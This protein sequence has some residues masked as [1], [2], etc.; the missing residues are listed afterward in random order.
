MN[1]RVRVLTLSYHYAL[2]SRSA[3]R[4]FAGGLAWIG[5][6]WSMTTDPRTEL[7][8]ICVIIGKSDGIDGILVPPENIGELKAAINHLI[9]AEA[10]RQRLSMRSVEVMKRFNLTKIADEWEILFKTVVK[11]T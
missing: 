11:K 1:P 4:Y 8:D 5:G 7:R 3:Q 2:I 10:E 9:S 6:G